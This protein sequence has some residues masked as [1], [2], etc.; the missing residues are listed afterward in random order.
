[1]SA[2]AAADVSLAVQRSLV[3]K[4]ELKSEFFDYLLERAL[5][6]N[7]VQTAVSIYSRPAYGELGAYYL[8]KLRQLVDV[9]SFQKRAQWDPSGPPKTTSQQKKQA[10]G[11][12]AAQDWQVFQS[13][14]N[15]AYSFTEDFLALGDLSKEELEHISRIRSI[16]RV[17]ID[18]RSS[19]GRWYITHS[20]YLVW[21][22][23]LD[24]WLVTY[25]DGCTF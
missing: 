9:D 6:F 21:C 3:Q 22:F 15:G 24:T 17:V 1:M 19:P 7:D 12:G 25:P 16:Q 10:A 11:S 2:A 5:Q 14:V 8:L 20:D 18:K 23:D 4:D 13:A